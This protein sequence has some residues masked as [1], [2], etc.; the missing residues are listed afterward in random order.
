M[1]RDCS[2]CSL[3]CHYSL[4]GTKNKS[5]SE[6]GAREIDIPI[7]ASSAMTGNLPVLSGDFNWVSFTF[8][9]YVGRVRERALVGN[10]YSYLMV[11]LDAA[12]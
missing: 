6:K 2:G 9:T 12:A 8:T 7:T 11:G 3:Q 10:E 1:Y 4:A 5:R